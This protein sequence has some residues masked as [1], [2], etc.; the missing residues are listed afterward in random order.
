VNGSDLHLALSDENTVSIIERDTG[1]I[2]VDFIR[3]SA[4]NY[5]MYL[6]NGG[7]SAKVL[8]ENIINA[9]NGIVGLDAS[10]N[11]VIS[12]TVT[13][14]SLKTTT[15]AKLYSTGEDNFKLITATNTPNPNL[16]I[17]Y[18]D[19]A[20]SLDTTKEYIVLNGSAI[21][22]YNSDL[23]ILDSAKKILFGASSDVNLYRGADNQLKTDDQFHAAGGN[24]VNI[25]TKTAAYTAT[26]ADD[27][28]LCNGTFTVTLPTASSASGVKLNIKNIGTGAIT[29]D[30]NS[31]ETIDGAATQT[32]SVQYNSLTIISNGSAW[33]VI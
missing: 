17:G 13:G 12:G 10:R 27:V 21:K 4:Y 19:G 33:Y 9:A 25:A 26:I 24:K 15:G 14:S 8:T 23:K 6:K 18:G 7:A 16:S 30:G 3:D 22:V 11:A 1:E 29:I 32:I 31:A 5:R 28:I 2:I 20:G